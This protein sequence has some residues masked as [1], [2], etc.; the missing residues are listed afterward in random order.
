MASSSRP[1]PRRAA[2]GGLASRL[3]ALR[4]DGRLRSGRWRSHRGPCPRGPF[5]F[6]SGSL[7]RELCRMPSA[8]MAM[9]AC[10][11][12]QGLAPL[13]P[14]A[15]ACLRCRAWRAQGSPAAPVPGG[16][17]RRAQKGACP[18]YLPACPLSRN[19]A[20]LPRVAAPLGVCGAARQRIGLLIR[21]SWV[22]IPSDPLPLRPC[23]APRALP[24]PRPARRPLCGT[25]G[26]NFSEPRHASGP[27]QAAPMGGEHCA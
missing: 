10:G 18:R 25:R 27:V 6:H 21:L 12:A 24:P 7:G 2:A 1:A 15:G 26:F 3:P 19:R 16:G 13:R 9:A 23:H 8:A 11:I 17:G 20:K 4:L 5:N 22:R 14:A